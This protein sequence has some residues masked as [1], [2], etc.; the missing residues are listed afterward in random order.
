MTKTPE[1]FSMN[2]IGVVHSCFKEKF[3]IPR[4]PGLAPQAKGRLTLYSPYASRDAVEGLE[5]SSHIW[6]QFLFHDVEKDQWKPSVR[7]PRLGGNKTRGVFATRSPMR[8]NKIGLSAVKLEG[9]DFQNGVEL[10]IG[11]ID[12]LD[13]TPV[14]DVKPYVPYTDKIDGADNR[15]AAEPPIHLPVVFSLDAAE[16]CKQQQRNYRESL[17]ELIEQVLQQDPRPQYHTIDPSRIYGMKLLGFDLKWRYEQQENG[18]VIRVLT[19]QVLPA[20]QRDDVGSDN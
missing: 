1:N 19:L 15:F 14:L 4:Q 3:G 17:R 8:P 6:V 2:V 10:L 12:L 20:Q 18:V 16:A 11:G 9:I 7:P 5:L 13:G